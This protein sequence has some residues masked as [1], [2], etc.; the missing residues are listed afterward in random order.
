[1]HR[2]HILNEIAVRS[3]MKPSERDFRISIANSRPAFQLDRS[4]P[5][6]AEAISAVRAIVFIEIWDFGGVGPMAVS[7]VRM[8]NPMLGF[9]RG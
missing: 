3:S 1:M 9:C 6:N 8:G 2:K 4:Q 7:L 5:Q